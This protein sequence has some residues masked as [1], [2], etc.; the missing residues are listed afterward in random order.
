MGYVKNE[1][2]HSPECLECGDRIAYGR[3]DKKF[4]CDACKNRYN[5]RRLRAMRTVKLKV[6]NALEKNHAIL[7]RLVKLKITYVN[8]VDIS[9]QGFDINYVTYYHRA[10]NYDEFRCFDIKF[11]ISG[12]RVFSIS[13]VTADLAEIGKG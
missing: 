1:D 13:R 7:E 4:C 12:T 8:V 9:Q 5:N 2:R 11:R 3:P 10:G 6:L